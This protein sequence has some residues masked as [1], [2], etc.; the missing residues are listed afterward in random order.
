MCFGVFIPAGTCVHVAPHSH[1]LPA[2]LL[3]GLIAAICYHCT[4]MLRLGLARKEVF[5]QIRYKFGGTLFAVLQKLY[6]EGGNLAGIHGLLTM[7]AYTFFHACLG[8]RQLA[9]FT[10]SWLQQL[11]YCQIISGSLS[12]GH[13]SGPAL[14]LWG[15]RRKRHGASADGRPAS[16]GNNPQ[17]K[18]TTRQRCIQHYTFRLLDLQV[19]VLHRPCTKLLCRLLVKVPVGV[20]TFLGSVSSAAW[21]VIITPVDTCKTILQTDGTKG[22]IMLKEKVSKG[23]PLILWSG[24]EGNYMANVI[25]NYPWFVT[26][27]LLQKRVTWPNSGGHL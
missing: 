24:W 18:P 21:R 4:Y 23:G 19:N 12:L 8:L 10:P 11:R 16:T 2:A 5:G 13:L 6:R 9:M 27:N 7:Q 3:H 17:F 20:T 1:E 25:G 26:M 15:R 14:S 22:W